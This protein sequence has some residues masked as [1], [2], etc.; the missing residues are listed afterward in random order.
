MG[1]LIVCAVF[2][3]LASTLSAHA[4]QNVI[5]F[6]ADGL[7]AAAVTPERAP[8]FARI[9]DT[10]VNFSNSHSVYPTIT[11]SN[12][13]VIAT[14]HLIG[15]TGDF[16]N[17][18][19]TGFPVASAAGT[20]TPFIQNNAV[21]SELNQ[22]HGGNFIAERS[23][24]AAA[25][26][27]GY[28]TAAL[29]KV[30]PVA[31]HDLTQL[32]GKTTI[33]FDDDTGKKDGIVLR[34]D[35]VEMLKKAGLALETPGRAQRENPGKATNIVQQ[36]YYRD[37]VTKV[38]LPHF[39]ENKKPFMLLY[40]S[41]DPDG[42]QHSQ[43]DSVNE[44]VPGINGPTSLA[45]I[46]VADDD[47]AA[48]VAALKEL[49]LEA[50]TNIFVTA[51]HGFSTVSKQSKTSPAAKLKYEN[52]PEGQLPPGFLAI[53]LAHALGLPLHEPSAQGPGIDYR[54]GKYP[55]RAS[56]SIG[57][58]PAKPDVVIGVNGGND[59]VY[60]PQGN[61]KTL[62]RQVVKAL[63]A[64]DYT[65]GVFVRDD[66]GPIPGTLPLSRI[67]LKGGA[68]TPTPAI[69]VNFRS[70]TTGCDQPL[71]CSVTVSDTT[72]LQ[73]QGHHGSF[74]RADTGNFM[75][76]IGPA[77]KTGFNNTAPVSNADI[78][79]TL[80][81]ILGVTLPPVGKLRGRALTEALPGGKPARPW[82]QDLVSKRGDNGLRTIVNMQF[83][84]LTRYFDAAG[85]PGRT[86]GLKVPASAR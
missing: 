80:E 57:N 43:R 74:S 65:S 39:K 41:S 26:D 66:L 2:A 7:R 14:G 38:L 79:P 19:Y 45:A 59:L 9:R 58:D 6:V 28:F 83:V 53:D 52:V 21:L 77:F 37:I 64:Q 82:R 72:L 17:V 75:A 76:A 34:P 73:G 13:S 85:F 1:K 24:M 33:F 31:I 12:A 71:F 48:I 36:K 23:I 25:R 46:K 63:L 81:K 54:S 8:T 44:L 20:I 30:G 49:G 50:D 18:F 11:T 15:D 86:V 16:G 5:L 32:D 10:G 60:L 40:W 68:R 61:A 29:G 47:L 35:L 70:E 27:K 62:A 78:A 51:D 42:T 22:H 84:G 56:A 3:V 67:G 55:R 69:V 4:Q